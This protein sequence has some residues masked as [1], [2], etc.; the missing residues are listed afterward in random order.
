LAPALKGAFIPHF[1]DTAGASKFVM[2][3]L[4]VK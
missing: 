4:I 2:F 1:E 3:V